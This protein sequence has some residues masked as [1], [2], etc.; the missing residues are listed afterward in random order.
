MYL[1]VVGWKAW[2][3][4]GVGTDAGCFTVTDDW[5][6]VLTAEVVTAAGRGWDTKLGNAD[7]GATLESRFPALDVTLGGSTDAEDD[8]LLRDS[9]EK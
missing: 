8:E 4:V 6:D 9:T 3:G 2:D 1:K 5:A 7:G